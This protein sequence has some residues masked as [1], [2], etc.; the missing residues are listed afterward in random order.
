MKCAKIIILLAFQFVVCA[1][2]CAKDYNL[3]LADHTQK[4]IFIRSADGNMVWK[5][6][7]NALFEAWML[8]DGSII[9]STRLTVERIVPDLETGQGGRKLWTYK[10]GTGAATPEKPEG[11]I[12]GCTPMENGHFLV[13]ESGT[14]RLVE[15]D[16]GG[17]VVHTVQLPKPEGEMRYTLRLTRHT[18]RDTF[19]VSF[20]WEGK[21]IEF[22]RSGRKLREFDIGQFCP[23]PENSAY[24]AVPMKDGG[25]LVS[26][27][28]Q[29]QII[30]LNYEGKVEWEFDASDLPAG[31]TFGW[32]TK[33]IPLEN[34]N[35]IFCNY[36][37]GTADVKA[38]E[39]TPG[40]EIVWQLN[41][42]ALKGLTMLQLLDD[43][44]R[45]LK[46]NT[47]R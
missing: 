25:L 15:I 8:N 37:K 45:P 9:Y 44:F 5:H 38:F 24:E 16:D 12:Y 10:F 47:G 35:F 30:L 17:R 14:F 40:K 23:T 22:D 29:N 43:N 20:F 42:P 21:I 4:H 28:P 33:V 11:M 1:L 2:V 6:P 27:G 13:T 39:V 26:C 36:C 7:G 31:M 46:I 19:L 34:G 32:I 3:L 18:P 41:D